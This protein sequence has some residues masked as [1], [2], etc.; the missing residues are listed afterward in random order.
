MRIAYLIL[1]H[2][3]P[4]QLARM[5]RVLEYDGASFYLH[6][7]K[8]SPI[9]QFI[10]L[11]GQHSNNNI[12]WLDRRIDV[13]WG[14]FSMVE[15]I[16]ALI[17]EAVKDGADRYILLS[18]Q[19]YSIKPNDYIFDFFKDNELNYLN[20]FPIPTD[21]W[22][23]SG[24]KWSNGGLD[25]INKYYYKDNKIVNKVLRGINKIS[26]GRKFPRDIMPYGGSMWWCLTS[27]C[28]MNILDYIGS[29]KHVLSFYKY[30]QC[31]DELF[32]QTIVLNTT[33]EKLIEND[34]LRFIEWSV[35]GASSPNVLQTFHYEKIRT[36][37]ALF[38]RK[39]DLDVS[40]DILSMIEEDILLK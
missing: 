21:D 35:P 36:S 2:N 26:P 7:D 13:R 30:T 39:F 8:K 40:G 12:K 33:D 32:F 3:K 6:V 23:G 29:N 9:D 28:V 15:A 19:D 10:E 4:D 31:P 14:G 5:L 17:K 38:A 1:A 16:L 27:N 20:Y 37:N 11:A 18:G 22:A 25:R 24:L 34:N